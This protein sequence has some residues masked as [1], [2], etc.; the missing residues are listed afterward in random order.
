MAFKSL[1]RHTFIQY[2]ALKKEYKDFDYLDDLIKSYHVQFKITNNSGFD[3]KKPTLT[4]RLPLDKQHPIDRKG[5]QNYSEQSFSSNL[6]NDQKDICQLDFVNTRI[7]SNSNVPYWNN[8]DTFI[9]WIRMAIN[10][11]NLEPFQ[12]QVSVNCE[13]ADGVSYKV[14][15]EPQKDLMKLPS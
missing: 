7:L 10:N 2:I 4:F 15:V 11:E 8:K 14:N 6:F 12:V 9:I 13:N 3:W 1:K 5:G